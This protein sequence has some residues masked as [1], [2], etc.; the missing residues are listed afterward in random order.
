MDTTCWRSSVC[1][2]S[3]CFSKI[4]YLP[5]IMNAM[6]QAAVG[7]TAWSSQ[8]CP[9]RCA[10]ERYSRNATPMPTVASLSMHITL[11]VQIQETCAKVRIRVA[12]APFPNFN[13]R[14]PNKALGS[15]AQHF[16]HCE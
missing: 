6:K 3:L 13:L 11:A 4:H 9:L 5:Q 1:A 8:S 12:M 16:R 2:A 14:I 15:K 7:D 10:W